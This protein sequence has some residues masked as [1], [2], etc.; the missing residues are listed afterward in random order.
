[1]NESYTYFGVLYDT[2]NFN[3]R[4][5]C[6]SLSLNENDVVLCDYGKRVNLSK[7]KIKIGYC[8]DFNVDINVMVRKTLKGLMDKEDILLKLKDKY[9]L[10]YYLERVV[11]INEDI[12]PLLSLDYDVV[13]F[14]Y[15]SES[16]DDLDYYII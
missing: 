13:S 7:G 3:L 10:E 11:Y 15:K 4:D 6:D 9:D 16:I 5:F 1:M 2:N 8:N 14:L 12:K